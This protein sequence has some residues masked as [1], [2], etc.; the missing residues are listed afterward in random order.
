MDFKSSKEAYLSQF[1]QIE[2]Y[3]I[4]I[5]ENGIFDADGKHIGVVEPISYRS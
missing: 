5:S 2:G 1:F 3:D 4:A